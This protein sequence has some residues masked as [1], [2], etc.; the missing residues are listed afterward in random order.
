MLWA[1]GEGERSERER[2]ADAARSTAGP[3]GGRQVLC[4]ACRGRITTTGARIEVNGEHQH[5]CVNPGGV[6]FDIGCFATAPGCLGHGPAESHWSW[7]EG[8]QW[9]IALCRGCRRHLGWSF[10]RG[11]DAFHGL[12]LTRLVEEEAEHGPGE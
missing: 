2:Q 6:V 12:V 3:G 9:R 5:V 10:E 4:A 1:R 11:D 7:F 8:Y